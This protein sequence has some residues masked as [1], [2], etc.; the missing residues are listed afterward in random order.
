MITLT[1]IILPI[2]NQWFP[3]H[4]Q[5]MYIRT[6]CIKWKQ[7]TFALAHISLVLQQ[8]KLYKTT[9][10]FGHQ[11]WCHRTNWHSSMKRTLPE[12]DT[13]REAKGNWHSTRRDMAPVS[14]SSSALLWRH[15]L[16]SVY[17]FSLIARCG[18]SSPVAIT[19]KIYAEI[20][21]D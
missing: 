6:I 15:N 4:I 19:S 9:T 3:N 7:Q 5:I 21:V 1:N 17:I 20:V 16:V 2:A 18:V 10:A 11:W 8:Q 12:C 13:L 14:R